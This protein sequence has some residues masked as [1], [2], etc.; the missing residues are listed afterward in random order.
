MCAGCLTHLLADARLKDEQAK[1][2]NCR[3]D[4]SRNVCQRN[5]AVEKTVSELPSECRH[6]G[7]ELARVVLF[8]HEKQECEERSLDKYMFL[9]FFI[10]FIGF[11]KLKLTFLFAGKQYI[12]LM[13]EISRNS[14]FKKFIQLCSIQV[15][16]TY[17]IHNSL[18]SFSVRFHRECLGT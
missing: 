4:I 2:P 8:R 14:F 13:F 3:T 12:D 17:V 16:N 7:K 9:F 5:L 11:T 15:G 10:L 18:C 6:C 1:C